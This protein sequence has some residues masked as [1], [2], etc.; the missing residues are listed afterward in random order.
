MRR[1]VCQSVSKQLV[2]RVDWQPSSYCTLFT[3]SGGSQL[4][5]QLGPTTTYN[6]KTCPTLEICNWDTRHMRPRSPTDQTAA[7]VRRWERRPIF[8]HDYAGRRNK[9]PRCCLQAAIP[10][11]GRRGIPGCTLLGGVGRGCCCKTN[12]TKDCA[13]EW[14]VYSVLCGVVLVLCVRAVSASTVVV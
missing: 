4:P 3:A 14:I 13:C 7:L 2:A 12:D 1:A 6:I 11:C 9:F 5:H 8:S 10:E